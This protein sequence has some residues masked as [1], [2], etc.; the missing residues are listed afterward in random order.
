MFKLIVL[1]IAVSIAMAWDADAGPQTSVG[2]M[3][4]QGY[5]DISTSVVN[6][7]VLSGVTSPRGIDYA[8]SF[9]T[10]FITDYGSDSFYAVNPSSGA[11]T[12]TYAIDPAIPDVLGIVY[13]L[14]SYSAFVNDWGSVMDIW[15][16]TASTWNF[17]FTGPYTSEPRG[18]AMDEAGTIWGMDASTHVLYNFDTSGTVI[19]SWDL[20]AEVPSGFSCG[21]AV[22]PYQGD[23]GIVMGGY[24]WSDFYYFRWDGVNMVL[25]GTSTT[26]ASASSSYGL[27]YSSD[28]DS[29]FWV[30]TDG[31]SFHLCQ[32]DI[33]I[34]ALQRETWAGIKSA[35]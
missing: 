20:N 27:T 25:L 32:F 19:D 8:D 10:I 12:A 16:Y 33:T 30:Y 17:G 7:F 35:F 6:D 5:D 3:N 4:P 14:V 26:P 1:L 22:F 24:S 2:P 11:I 34:T 13:D 23:L 18:M 15:Y 31:G 28:L 29:F 21:I 9:A